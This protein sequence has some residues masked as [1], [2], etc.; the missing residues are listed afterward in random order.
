MPRLLLI[1][2]SLSLALTALTLNVWSYSETVE[3]ERD[4]G[5]MHFVD[6]AIYKGDVWLRY[7]IRFHENPLKVTLG[8]RAGTAVGTIF[9]IKTTVSAYRPS[10]FDPP[11]AGQRWHTSV[12]TILFR[13]W[14]LIAA[15]CIYPM[16][17]YLTGFIRRRLRQSRNLCAT[18]GYDLS[19]CTTG[20]CSE[21][22]EAI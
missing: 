5:K 20:V 17:H 12:T 6:L 15:L 22:G 14:I 19:G 1:A 4:L 9:S 3:W 13:L 18:C 8:T 10:N 21:C 7:G 16:V 2:V 11:P